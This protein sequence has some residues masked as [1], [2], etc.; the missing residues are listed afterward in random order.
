VL[1][2]TEHFTE[3]ILM[4]TFESSLSLTRLGRILLHLRCA[5]V[6]P[7]NWQWHWQGIQREL[8]SLWSSAV[9]QT[10]RNP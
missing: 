4:K 7:S 1:P 5:F 9:S 8:P 10:Y 2:D 3:S 6:R